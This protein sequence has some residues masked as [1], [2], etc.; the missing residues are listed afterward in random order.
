MRT[1]RVA[2]AVLLAALTLTAP[3]QAEPVGQRILILGSSTTACAGPS[4]P[5]KCYINIVKAARP[6]DTVTVVARG[7]TYIGYGTPAQNWT[8]AAIPSGNDAVL[9]QLGINDWYVPVPPATLRQ[10]IDQLV[11]RVK[12][13]NPGARIGWV[14]TWMPAQGDTS[15]ARK[16]MWALHGQYTAD[17]MY[18]ARQPGSVGGAA[19]ATFIDL[20]TS[21]GPRRSTAPGDAGWHYNDF[22]HAEI[23]DGVLAWLATG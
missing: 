2:L 18:Y 5:A 4:T 3:A 8:T 21:P 14:R 20:G 13:A 7:G 19:P 16:A 9:I 6:L 1:I 11:I 15:D 10:Q 23:A 22:G 12:A 17:A